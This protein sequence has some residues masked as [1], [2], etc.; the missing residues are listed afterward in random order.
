MLSSC[1]CQKPV[2]VQPNPDFFVSVEKESRSARTWREMAGDMEPRTPYL[3]DPLEKNNLKTSLKAVFDVVTRKPPASLNSSLDLPPGTSCTPC[4]PASPSSP[5]RIHPLKQCPPL[6]S[7]AQGYHHICSSCSIC[8]FPALDHQT[9]P[10]LG[11]CVHVV[12]GVDFCLLVDLGDHSPAEMRLCNMTKTVMVTATHQHR[13]EGVYKIRAVVCEWYGADM[14]LGPYYVETGLEAVSVFMNSSSVH[15]GEFLIFA[16]SN[17]KQ[18]RTVIMHRFSPS[19][20][21]NVSFISRSQVGDHQTWLSVPVRYE[22]QPVSVYTN[23]TVFAVNT[24]ITFMAVTKETTPLEFFWYFGEDLPVPTTSRI[25]RRRL[26]LPQWYH[27][28]VKASSSIGSVVSEPH[29]IRVQKRIVANRLVSASSAVINTS[30]AFEYRINFGTDVVYRW[31][32]GDGTVSS[33]SGS[34]SHI[35]SRE[36]EFRVEVLAFNNISSAALRKQLF[37]VREPCQPPPV[38]NM[39]PAKVQIWRSQ[40]L[41]LEVTFE[42]P[43][44][45][46]ISQGLSYTW[47]F[48]DS[49]RSFVVLPGGIH[50]HRQTILL[51]SYTLECGN[52]TAIAKVQIKGSVVYSNYCVAVEVRS[53]APVSVISAGTHLFVPRVTTVPIVLSGSRSYDPDDPHAILRYLWVC[54][55]ANS[56]GW[57]CFDNV[58]PHQLD[59]RAP[60]VSFP[61]RWLNGFCDQFLVT[62]TVSS[63]DRNSSEAQVFLSTR[64]DP[65][66]RFIHLFWV[67][68]K[69]VHVNWNE[70]LLLQA[71]CEH[72]EDIHDLSYSWDLFLVNATEKSRMEV[73]FC[74]TVGL[75]GAS[76]LE[77]VLKS[78]ESNL[79]TAE[80]H[81]TDGDGRP[82]LSSRG[83]SLSTLV[84][85]IISVVDS[86]SVE[87][88]RDGQYIP[89]PGDTMAPGESPEDGLQS[90][91]SGSLA[92]ESWSPPSSS[93][94][95]DD[96]E[97]Y[98]S[99]IQEAVPSRGRQPGNNTSSAGSGPG[100]HMEES[101]YDGDNLLGPFLSPDRAEPVLMTDWR[102]A[103]ISPAA[104]QGYT[105]SGITGSSVIIKPYSLRS[106]EMYVLQASVAS[107]HGLRGR[108]Q[109]YF[110]VNPTPQDMA[111]QVQP[112][113]GLE[114]QTIFSVFCLSG[115]PDFHYEF[116]Y[117][118]GNA[119]KHTLYRG[120]DTHYY[121]A[122]PA[123]KPVD[124]YRVMVSTEITDGEG[125]KVQPCTA[126]V[127]VM[128]RFH[129]NSCLSEDLYNSSL[130]SLSTLQLMGSHREIRNF[131]TLI[132]G[133]LRRLAKENT[134]ASC[135]W[136]SQMQ[137]TFV[138]S[139]CKLGFEDQV[140]LRVGESKLSV[141]LHKV[142]R[143]ETSWSPWHVVSSLTRGHAYETQARKEGE[144][145]G[146]LAPAHDHSVSLTYLFPPSPLLLACFCYQEEI[147]D[148]ILL[149][150]DLIGLPQKL[151]FASAV[152][153]L[154]YS[155]SL[156]AHGQVLERFVGDK[157]LGLELILL[158]S[159]VWEASKQENLKNENYLR[160]EG[161]KVISDVLLKCLSLSHKHGFHMSTGQMEFWILLHHNLQSSV[162][163]LGSIQV[164]LPGDLAG[165]T[166]A[167]EEI[168][169]PCYISQLLFFK[170][171]PYPGVP[172]PEQVGGV[173]GVTLYSC[174]SRRPIPRGQL[175]TPMTVEF[176]E[177]A[178][179]NNK[180]N[181]TMFVLLRNQVNSH[182]FTGLSGNS[183]GSLQIHIEFSNGKTRAFPVMLLVRFFKKPTPSD[184]LVKQIHSWDGQTTDI[185]IP[186]VL[187]EGANMGYLSLLDADYDR[188]PPNKNFAKALNYTV[189]FQWLQC[190]FWDKREWKSESFSPQQG[191]SPGKVNCSYHRLAS[192]SLLRN[193]LNSSF[194]VS[195]IS[196][197]QKHPQNL[198][199]SFLIVVLAILY[200]FLVTK[201]NYVD[202]HNKKKIGYI[203]LQ[204]DTPPGHRLYALVM[205]TGFLSPARFTSKVFVVLCGKNGLSETRELCCPEKP[206]FQGNPQH[207]FILSVSAQLGPLQKI[208]LW[209]DCR[210]HSPSLY[211]SHMMVKDLCSGQGWFFPA[212]CWL[213]ASRGDGHVER[214]LT[215]LRRGLGFQKLFYFK[216]TEYLQESHIWLSMYS[217]LSS[218]G[219]LPVPQ[220]AVSFC[221][222]CTYAYLTAL[223]TSGGHEQVEGSGFCNGFQ[224]SHSYLLSHGMKGQSFI[225]SVLVI[226]TFE[227]HNSY[228]F[229]VSCISGHIIATF[230]LSQ[231]LLD[232]GSTDVTLGSIGLSLL[233][234]FLASP[235]AHLLSLFFRLS[236]DATGRPPATAG[237]SLKGAQLDAPQGP[238]SCGRIPDV[239]DPYKHPAPVIPSG[240]DLMWRKRGN[241]S[242][243]AGTILELEACEVGHYETALREKNHPEPAPRRAPI[244]GFEGFMTQRSKAYLPWLSSAGWII[245]GLLSLACGTGTGF[246]GYSFVPAQCVQWLCLLSLSVICCAFVTQP[247]MICCMALAFA[248]KRKDDKEFFTESLCEATRSVALELGV[249]LGAQPAC[250]PRRASIWAEEAEK[251][252]AARRRERHLRWAR[253]PSTARLRVIRERL[254]RHSRNQAALRDICMSIVTLLLLLLIIYG[255]VS[256]EERSLNQAFRKEFIRKARHSVEDLSGPDVWWDWSVITLLDMLYPEAPRAQPGALGGKCYLIGA[257]VIKQLKVSPHS[258]CKPSSPFWMLSEGSDPMCNPATQGLEN[259]SVISSD[260]E[261][262]LHILGRTRSE[263]NVGLAALRASQWIDQRTRA[264]STHFTL[265]NPA[266]RLFSSVTLSVEILPIGGLI[267]SLLVESFS[268]FHSDS[269]PQ[270]YLMLPKLA[271]L[272]LHAASLCLQLCGMAEEDVFSWWSKPRTWLEISG[273]GA[274]LAFFLASGHLTTLMEDAADQFR[275]GQGRCLVLVDLSQVV[276]WN[277]RVQ[278]LRGLLFFFWMCKCIHALGFLNKTVSCSSTMRLFLIRDFAPALAGLLVLVAH[279]HLLRFLL[280]TWALPSD[281]SAAPVLW[282]PFCYLGRSQKDSFHSLPEAGQRSTARYCVAFFLVVAATSSR[283]T[284]L[285]KRKSIRRQSFVTLQDV[286][287]DMWREVQTLLGLEKPKVEETKEAEECHYYLDECSLLID[288]LLRK[289][290]GL[291]DSLELPGLENQPQKT[292]EQ[293]VDGPP[294]AD[295]SQY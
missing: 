96:F 184:F 155:Q 42:A 292:M 54:T 60:T 249:G 15:Q 210:G 50:T 205:T 126:A 35:Y 65:A 164:H 232:V 192:F 187:Q 102:K 86:M 25:I 219:H 152:H 3:L 83:P 263:A 90:P 59:A 100:A 288:E 266:A 97:A 169:R 142:V 118:L 29:L 252:L 226:N 280:F 70:E 171:S 243:V 75:L 186:A 258:P 220:L 127:T 238:N 44:H 14:E 218:S 208:R 89:A 147:I 27:V 51:P 227:I 117:R 221:L 209:H 245:C 195:D 134:A 133:I 99:D 234:T 61:A 137:D 121:F 200:G 2:E 255:Q 268:I 202:W 254:R 262:C 188:K 33:G 154:R 290:N 85:S 88:T 211:I 207:I 223:V 145:T 194:E 166:L 189:H 278:W 16:G 156:L 270:Y 79:L 119:S 132:T 197:L 163:S 175:Q 158:V 93:P 284:F 53:R 120:R 233:C 4:C 103:Q 74:S 285:R 24:D 98:Y 231:P 76:A 122:L 261:A 174:A 239:Q 282:M 63:G 55:V 37:I 151:S 5:E 9:P 68:F 215:C 294:L 273:A 140:W 162:Q 128:P 177:D 21:Y 170:K 216:F 224:I 101:P 82:T 217:W 91:E 242:G 260:P 31:D 246:L 47:Y 293:R 241:D 57:P 67:N 138:S 56:P 136:W 107:K 84:P 269:A 87:P 72:C 11:F 32:F 111:C 123:G 157:G 80:P 277:Q 23:G 26:H 203:C 48:L 275:Q 112:H 167:Q 276:L 176:R 81:V 64:A 236:K 213:A 206:L 165:L 22:M 135:G 39:G 30:V 129:G 52:Y 182:Q 71:V 144:W 214:E 8:C 20:S 1:S 256:P 168:Q 287:A 180:S 18:K 173:V 267:P 13:R 251:V 130:K 247:F 230:G 124:G 38:K 125:S 183:Q 148:S 196:E 45:C 116:S 150:R 178:S 153:I 289:I 199:P 95:L 235:A 172:G 283:M 28:T 159:G 7:P 46:D 66:F 146:T 229:G 244:S 41:K 265:Y 272:L 257:S 161:M 191:T 149:L 12:S 110:S 198:L 62:L 105:A 108:A 6:A 106:G 248:W 274:A 36:G 78:S 237:H 291:S 185:Y 143:P 34:V 17:L 92:E 73:R 240:S 58:T 131:I 43:V 139:L 160:E 250:T 181:T 253:P 179:P 212:Q 190:M 279:F 77:G 259:Q 141:N 193:K 94:A 295:I 222:L 40:P 69:D 104:F 19:S 228:A 109:L 264:V 271:F 10:T 225:C 114:A 281:P 201:N 113:H 286:A 49:Q 115:K 204:E